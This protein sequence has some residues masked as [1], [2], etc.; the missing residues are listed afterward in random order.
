MPL[1]PPVPR[2]DRH[3]YLDKV[4]ARYQ[5]AQASGTFKLRKY[6]EDGALWMLQRDLFGETLGNS[7]R[8]RPFNKLYGG[9]LCGTFMRRMHQFLQVV[10]AHYVRPAPVNAD[11]MGLGKTP[12]ALALIY[13]TLHRN[14]LGGVLNCDANVVHPANFD[15]HISNPREPAPMQAKQLPTL[16]VCPNTATGMWLDKCKE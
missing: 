11:D 3:E 1:S 7:R 2:D 14:P 4:M 6:Q 16:I 9:F 5:Y 8:K 12:Q 10:A 15:E 13:V